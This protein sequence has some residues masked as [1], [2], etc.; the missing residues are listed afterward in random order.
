MSIHPTPGLG[1]ELDANFMLRSTDS[2]AKSQLTKTP[3]DRAAE[4]HQNCWLSDARSAQFLC[5]DDTD[6]IIGRSRFNAQMA[7]NER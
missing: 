2:R 1:R 5:I 6:S 3:P 4:Q 7:R